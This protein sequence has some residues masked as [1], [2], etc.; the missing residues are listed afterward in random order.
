MYHEEVGRFWNANADAWTKLARAGYDVYRDYLNTPAFFD[1]LPN[2]AGLAGLDIGCGE[3][4]NTRLLAKCGARVTAIDIAETFIANARQAE[5]REPL[6][7]D[8]RVASA[9]DLPFADANFDFI[10]AFMSFMDIPQTD[11]VLAEA[12]RVLKPCGFL[13][14]SISHPCFDTPHRRNLHD[15]HGLTY[16][17]EVGDYF[18]NLDG[19]VEEWLFGAAPLHA[20]QGLQKF[21]TPRFTRTISQWLNLLI[22]TGFL[23]E[24]VAEPRPGDETVRACPDMQDAQV[25]AYFLHIRVRRPEQATTSD[26]TREA[27][28]ALPADCRSAP[29]SG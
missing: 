3:G 1:M 21:K 23:L 13:Q 10:T 19:E 20:K 15:A 7:I 4:H 22:N 2:V 6:D 25:V 29:G 27:N 17:L 28:Q 11:R 12:Y 5:A 14:F 8:Y 26:G 9:V 16:A 18:R 24:R